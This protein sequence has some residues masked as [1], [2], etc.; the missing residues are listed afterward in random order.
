LTYGIKIKH[1]Y[2]YNQNTRKCLYLNR[3]ILLHHVSSA[4]KWL[5][6]FYEVLLCLVP[7]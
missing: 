3:L 1:I 6:W 5:I 2:T 7:W 4:Q